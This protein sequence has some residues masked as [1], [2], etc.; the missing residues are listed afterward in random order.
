MKDN[1]AS[2]KDDCKHCLVNSLKC[3]GNDVKTCLFNY[4][5][6]PIG[7]NDK[8]LRDRV[9]TC[10]NVCSNPFNSKHCENKCKFQCDQKFPDATFRPQGPVEYGVVMPEYPF[11]SDCHKLCSK[12]CHR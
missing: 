4:Y 2:P 8:C 1:K 12:R 10:N 3:Q 11:K 7:D 6:C 9:G 5:H